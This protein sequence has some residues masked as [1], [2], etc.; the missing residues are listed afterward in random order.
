MQSSKYI[1]IFKT[2][3][4]NKSSKP[5]LSESLVGLFQ[6]TDTH[7][8]SLETWK[9]FLKSQVPISILKAYENYVS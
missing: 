1:Y 8:A 4:H 6:H 5:W 2:N 3:D 7:A 9:I